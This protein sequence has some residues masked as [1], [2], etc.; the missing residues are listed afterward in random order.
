VNVDKVAAALTGPDGRIVDI[1]DLEAG[2]LP[3]MGSTMDRLAYGGKFEDV[4]A[5]AAA[6]ENIF[7]GSENAH[8]APYAVRSNQRAIAEWE[9][10]TEDG[11]ETEAPEVKVLANRDV[12]AEHDARSRARGQGRTSPAA[13]T[14]RA[15][16][17]RPRPELALTDASGQ[18]V[19]DYQL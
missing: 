6:R 7:A 19:E 12:L 10:A 5:A 16:R 1:E 11:L 8:F 15:P 17:P 14:V 13:T 18:E 3:G 2:A 9:R 4:L